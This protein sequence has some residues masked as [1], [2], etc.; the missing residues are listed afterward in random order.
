MATAVGDSGRGLN[1]I[2]AKTAAEGA[3]AMAFKG[4]F[5][6]RI[7]S[8]VPWQPCMCKLYISHTHMYACMYTMADMT[9]IAARMRA[10]ILT[11]THTSRP[12][13]P[14]AGASNHLHFM[15][16]IMKPATV[17]STVGRPNN[18]TAC[19]H[20]VHAIECCS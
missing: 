2:L 4:Q 16:L 5:R 15:Y 8:T 20:A 12:K 13:K 7:A 14:Y 18:C 17:Q 9:A 3:G 19:M 10:A 6:V 11:H 1:R